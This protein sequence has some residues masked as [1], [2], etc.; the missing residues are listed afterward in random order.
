VATRPLDVCD[1]CV[2]LLTQWFYAALK[3]CKSWPYLPSFFRRSWSFSVLLQCECFGGNLKNV[4]AGHFFTHPTTS[5]FPLAPQHLHLRSCGSYYTSERGVKY[6]I[7]NIE[8]EFWEYDNST[9]SLKMAKFSISA[10]LFISL[11]NMGCAAACCLLGGKIDKAK[12]GE[13]KRKRTSHL[14]LTFNRWCICCRNPP[15]EAPLDSLN[16]E[17]RLGRIQPASLVVHWHLSIWRGVWSGSCFFCYERIHRDNRW[18]LGGALLQEAAILRR[19][20]E[21]VRSIHYWIDRDERGREWHSNDR[22]FVSREMKS[23]MVH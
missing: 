12:E 18:H 2:C 21:H 14:K 16:F 7:W 10:A 8:D 22:N 4:Q 15:L 6:Q 3:G 13:S 1:V 19:Q 17:W 11:L 9:S 5:P 20:F 23:N